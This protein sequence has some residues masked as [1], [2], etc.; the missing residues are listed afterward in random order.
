MSS[1]VREEI[2]RFNQLSETWWDERGP[3]WPLH[4][5][6]ALR[7]PFIIRHLQDHFGCTTREEF[8]ALDV[9]DIGCGAGL[10]SESIAG[11]G[12]RVLGIDAAE[13]N[14]RI[15]RTHATQSNLTVDY[16][17]TTVEAL[18]PLSQYDVVLNMEVVEH[19]ADVN[20]FLTDCTR[21]VKPGGL[22]F[23]ATIN[24]TLYSAVTAILGAEYILGWLPKG[25]HQWQKFVKPAEVTNI[26]AEE[27]FSLIEQTGVSV[28]PV[29]RSMSLT[30]Y[31]GG[32]YMLVARRELST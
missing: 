24:R 18:D 9:L 23:I 29:K 15:A 7:T 17:H 14:I 21:R 11:T 25:T 27:D 32:N 1:I 10:L 30:S 6:N 19:V 2:E 8:G 16:Q 4:R 20:S 22:M 31:L 12:A 28:N 5:L 26:L 13:N 3:M